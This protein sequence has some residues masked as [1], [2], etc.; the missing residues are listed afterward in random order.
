MMESPLLGKEMSLIN[1][2]NERTGCRFG[3][4][5]VGWSHSVLTNGTQ[6]D[7]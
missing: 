2:V 3:G 5:A 4:H 1:V 7:C 6:D